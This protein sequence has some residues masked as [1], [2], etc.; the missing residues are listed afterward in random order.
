VQE[1]RAHSTF[2]QVAPAER[3]SMFRV[4][5]GIVG[6]C[7]QG[8]CAAA[9]TDTAGVRGTRELGLVGRGRRRRRNRLGKGHGATARMAG[10]PCVLA[11]LASL[12]QAALAR[13]CPRQ[14]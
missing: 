11:T 8:T 4:E 2:A 12:A 3:S 14:P 5:G 9:L 13:L 10:A 6:G 7:K 1:P